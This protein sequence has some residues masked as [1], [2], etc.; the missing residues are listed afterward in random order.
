[1]IESIALLSMKRK[2][3]LGNPSNARPEIQSGLGL[4]S[5]FAN[6]GAVGCNCT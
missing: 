1:M 2:G 5:R 3:R 4:A 6:N